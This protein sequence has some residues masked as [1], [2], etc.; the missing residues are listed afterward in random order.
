[1][2]RPTIS[3]PGP[4]PLPICARE[5][6]DWFGT[7]RG[8]LGYLV[9]PDLLIF[10]TGGFAYGEVKHTAAITNL[11]GVENGVGDP[12]RFTVNCQA[13]AACYT[14]SSSRIAIGY[15]VGGGIEYALMRNWTVKAEYLYVNLGSDKLAATPVSILNGP[16]Q[17]NV[18]A[19]YT[20]THFNLVRIGANYRF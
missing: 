3:Q 20:D 17:S 10:G 1:M 8:R 15:A 2:R 14:G 9:S 5:N 16:N 13:S 7:V 11:S 4:V 6:V 18:S 19:A 12:R